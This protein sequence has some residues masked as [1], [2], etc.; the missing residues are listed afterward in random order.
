MTDIGSHP[1]PRM[2]ARQA[3]QTHNGV[4][5]SAREFDLD[6]S[7][8][9]PCLNE[10]AAVGTCVETALSSIAASGMTGE[11]VVVD[12]DSTDASAELASAAG[13]RIVR[14]PIRG[15]GRAYLAGLARGARAIHRA[16]RFRWDLRLRRGGEFCRAAD[17]WNRHGDGQSPARIHRPRS[18]ALASQVPRQSVAHQDGERS[19][20]QSDIRC[21]LRNEVDQ[22]RGVATL[23]S[24]G[25]RYGVCPGDADFGRAQRHADQ[26]DPDS[27]QKAS[28][29]NSQ[30]S[31]LARRMAQP[32]IHSLRITRV[33][34]VA[35][36]GDGG[37]PLC[38]IGSVRVEPVRIAFVYDLIYPYSKGGVEKRI[39]DLAHLLSA[40]GHDV[41][42]LGTHSWDGPKEL[43]V[44]GIRFA[45]SWSR[46]G[47]TPTREDAPSF[48]R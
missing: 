21:V 13:A 39:W 18:H 47:S 35:S 44:D 5:E 12:N 30:A 8:V 17:Q 1:E 46:P 4:P 23:G 34:G 38:D 42:V 31:D 41:D 15:Y 37:D 6:I 32:P 28:R 29:R 48:R 19:L 9:M 20:L 43:L 45:G 25:H 14:E 40:R 7:I 36:C 3:P 22:A 26:G 33:R 27:L 2:Q 24:I 11:V 16:R 10:E